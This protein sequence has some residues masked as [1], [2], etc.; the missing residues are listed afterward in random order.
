MTDRYFESEEAFHS[1]D[2]KGGK[3]E[4]RRRQVADRSK[5]KKTDRVKQPPAITS[6]LPIGRVVSVTGE[7]ALVEAKGERH[8][9]SLRGLLKKERGLAKNLIAVGD[10]VRFSEG[11]IAAIEPRSSF[12]VRQEIRG[13]KEQLIAVNIDYALIVASISAPTLKPALIDRYLIAAERGGMHPIVVLNKIDLLERGSV[14]AL[15]YKEALAAYKALGIP[16][17]PVSTKT[18]RGLPTLRKMMKGK[19]SVFV[20]QSGVGKSSLLNELFGLKLRTGD[21]TDKTR[22]GS[23]TTS[24]AQ[25]ISLP[26]GGYCVDT[27]GVRSFALWNVPKEQ[28]SAYFSEITKYAEECRFPDC[29]HREEPGCAVTKALEKGLISPL[30]Y[31]SYISLITQEKELRR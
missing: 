7:G 8:L 18:G 27:P 30:R 3:K 13:M 16:I 31:E 19:C 12:L 21:L 11:S 24:S 20:G 17:V 4:R 14:E 25:L 1:L 26:H 6:D 9:C 22:K 2:R 5:F 23:H 28:I 15:V 10:F 29:A